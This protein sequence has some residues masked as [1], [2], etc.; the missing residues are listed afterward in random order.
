[1]KA[2]IVRASTT[3]GTPPPVTTASLNW[4]KSNF[5]PERLLRLRAQPVDLAVADL[6]AA[7]LT[8]PGAITI[9]FARHFLD[10]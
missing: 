6:V 5:A 8:R 1:M 4:R 9:D 3:I 2:S 7:G 10:A